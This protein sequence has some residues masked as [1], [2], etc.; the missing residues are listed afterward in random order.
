ML[1]CQT[2]SDTVSD[3]APARS[4]EDSL[5]FPRVKLLEKYGIRRSNKILEVGAGG[6]G[7]LKTLNNAGYNNVTGITLGD[8]NIKNAKE[9][10]DIDLLYMDM[11]FTSFPNDSFG[12][13]IGWHV[14]EHTPA[15]LLAG[16]EILR[17]LKPGGKILMEVP[18]GEPHFKYDSNAHHLNVLEDWQLRNILRKCG[19]TNVVVEQIKESETCVDGSVGK[20][21]IFYGE[22]RNIG[23]DLSVHL[24]DIAKGKFLN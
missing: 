3:G 17:I 13:V 7:T 1:D 4:P 19:F 20:I 2:G 22:K 14:F 6:G 5:N 10:Y 11:H 16:L 8:G 9:K 24:R 21:L 15:P 12:A 23:S 18:S